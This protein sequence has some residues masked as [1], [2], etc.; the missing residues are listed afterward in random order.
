MCLG[1]VLSLKG[2]TFGCIL[3]PKGREI[4]SKIEIWGPKFVHFGRFEGSF[5]TIL[6]VKSRFLDF[7]K[8]VLDLFGK[9]LSIV[10][11]L[12]VPTFGCILSSKGR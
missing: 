9:C 6:G 12:K 8:I 3:I 11:G 2:P 7:F 5:L 4:T 10:F 1:F